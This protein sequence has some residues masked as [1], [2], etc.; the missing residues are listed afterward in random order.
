M[1]T[2]LKKGIGNYKQ[3]KAFALRSGNKPAFKMMAG[4]SP[5]TSPGKMKN[6][7][8]GTGTSPYAQTT[9]V[10]DDGP[11]VYYDNEGN[12]ITAEEFKKKNVEGI[13]YDPDEK[14]AKMRSNAAEKD[15][16]YGK[17]T[18][19]EYKTE[20]LRQSKSHKEGK[21]WDANNTGGSEA[22][23]GG[24]EA[25][26]GGNET[27]TGENKGKN[28][29]KGKGLLGDKGKNILKTTANMFMAGI[30]NVYGTPKM[31]MSPVE[32]EDAAKKKADKETLTI[33][34][35]I[36]QDNKNKNKV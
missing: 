1:K 13:G 29:G 20:A 12:Q 23:T 10:D 21:G 26:T 3:G 7:G 27:S 2:P 33:A 28:T 30:N 24:S 25:S 14:W 31:G 5:I 19:K 32:A 6:F 4:K 35:K 34:Q 8:V 17:M 36:I 22:S 18:V 15:P 9:K 11:E 16:K